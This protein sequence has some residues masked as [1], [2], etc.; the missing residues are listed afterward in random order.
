MIPSLTHHLQRNL[1]RIQRPFCARLALFIGRS[2]FLP[3]FVLFPSL[4]LFYCQIYLQV[5]DL[6]AIRSAA[7]KLRV[8]PSFLKT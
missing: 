1:L 5:R 6:L 8:F 2:S 7:A 4:S 3:F